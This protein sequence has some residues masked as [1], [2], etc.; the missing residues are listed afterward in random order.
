MPVPVKRSGSG[1]HAPKLRWCR[2]GRGGAD[3]S[4]QVGFCVLLQLYQQPVAVAT[5][6]VQTVR[7]KILPWVISFHG[8]KKSTPEIFRR[9]DGCR[10]PIAMR[11][12][13]MHVRP[14]FGVS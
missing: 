13:K 12:V 14:A 8:H 9:A 1:R 6:A 7:K 3:L 2:D 10:S 4:P 5:T 11:H